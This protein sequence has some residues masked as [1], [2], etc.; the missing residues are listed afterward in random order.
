[1]TIIP[2]DW[3]DPRLDRH[4]WELGLETN[5][6]KKKIELNILINS[7]ID[8]EHLPYCGD[9]LAILWIVIRGK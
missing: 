9:Q 3:G 6:K 5:I 1:M 8:F 2:R 7:Q 4:H